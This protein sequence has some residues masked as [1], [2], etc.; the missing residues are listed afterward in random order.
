[1]DPIEKEIA[2][3]MNQA[4]GFIFCPSCF[5]EYCK[6]TNATDDIKEK[7]TPIY[8]GDKSPFSISLYFTRREAL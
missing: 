7:F 4:R 5:S 8:I 6:D 1:M 3:F 2:S